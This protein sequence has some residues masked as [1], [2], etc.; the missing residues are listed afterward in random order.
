MR[1]NSKEYVARTRTTMKIAQPDFSRFEAAVS[2]RRLPDRVPVAEVEV[3]FEI[4]EAF[5]GRPVVDLD[6]Y[7][8]FWQRAGYDY[9]LLQVRG[10]WLSD[11]FQTKIAEGIIR[12][13]D[14]RSVST[15]GSGRIH[16]EET[17]DTYPW[18]G[19]EGVYYKDVD[20]VE[21]CLPVGMKLVVNVGPLFSG[22]WRCMGLETFAFACV[23]SPP[24]VRA[25]VEKMGVLLVKIVENVCQREY[26][27]GVWLGDDIAYT[28]GLMVAPDF[29]RRQIFPFYRQIGDLCRRFGK[30]Y[31]YH[32]DGLLAEVMDDLLACGI[33]AIHPNEPTSV[34]IVEVKRR[35]GDRLALVGNVDVD[36]LARGTPQ[37][38]VNATRHLIRSVGPGGGFAL[39]SGNSVAKYVALENYRAMLDTARKYGE[40]Y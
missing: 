21:N 18:I 17:F 16:D 14:M 30:L 19:P 6:T 4:M 13:G 5:L 11:S 22:L 36:L 1:G 38:V 27:G 2:R 10:Q 39:G 9:A 35:W 29:L 37:Q 20:L 26:V 32:S 25:I 34:D 40:I 3:D 24:L 12:K 31:I 15:F 23:D 8:S 33:Q 28:Q 7:C